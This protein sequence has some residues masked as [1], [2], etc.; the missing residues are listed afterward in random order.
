MDDKFYRCYSLKLKEH[1]IANDLLPLDEQYS[2]KNKR[3]VWIFNKTDQF[4]KLLEEY[5]DKKAVK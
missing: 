2:K 3:N 4:I 5:Q 1:M